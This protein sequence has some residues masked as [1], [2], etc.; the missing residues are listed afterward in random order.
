MSK[1]ILICGG[2]GLL[3]VNLAIYFRNRAK[4]ILALNTKKIEIKNVNTKNI[5][6][7]NANDICSIIDNESIDLII[8]ASGYTNIEKCEKFVDEAIK[9]NTTI[10]LNLA[11]VSD[12]H[13]IKLV[14]ISTDH[15]FSGC[16]KFYKETSKIEPQNVYA[17]TKYQG[18]TVILKNCTNS[19]IIRTNFFGWG[20]VYRS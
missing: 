16:K 2:S 17:L 12:A 5:D 18:E 11:K 7:T 15:L 9:V 20:P 6:L 14:H 13:G 3:G 1:C 19:L 10:P 4:V 8:N